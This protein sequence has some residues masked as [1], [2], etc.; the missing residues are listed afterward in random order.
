MDIY[1]DKIEEK[2]LVIETDKDECNLNPLGNRLDNSEGIAII[3]INNSF[4]SYDE[5]RT[6]I[7]GLYESTI[8]YLNSV[9][10]SIDNC[11]EDNTMLAA[12]SDEEG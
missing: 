10:K 2:I 4:A 7:L 5:L 6:N 8:T 1:P 12:S 11:E 3:H 9:K